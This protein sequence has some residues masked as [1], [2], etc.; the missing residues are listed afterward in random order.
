MSFIPQTKLRSSPLAAA[1][2]NNH[3]QVVQFLI[4]HGA[5]V[6]YQDY[7]CNYCWHYMYLCY[8][9]QWSLQFGW[10]P[11]HFAAKNDRPEVVRLLLLSQANMELKNNVSTAISSLRAN[12]VTLL[13]HHGA[14]SQTWWVTWL[15]GRLVGVI[16]ECGW[17]LPQGKL[18]MCQDYALVMPM[19]AL[20]IKKCHNFIVVQK[21]V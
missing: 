4:N 14:W 12:H 17:E 7:V 6:D 1:C 5:D 2:V 20:K 10:S 9:L 13:D 21:L 16:C 19:A 3:L 18:S 15:V 8:Q 11:L